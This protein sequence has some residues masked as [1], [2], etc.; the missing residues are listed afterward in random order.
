MKH[1]NYKPDT[2]ACKLCILIDDS[3]VWTV[4]ESFTNSEG[5]VH[6]TIPC[7]AHTGLTLAEL[8]D[9]IFAPTGENPKK[10]RLR[11]RL[12]ALKETADIVSWSW[13]GTGRTR[14]LTVVTSGLTA[15]EKTIAQTWCD[16]NFGSGKIIVT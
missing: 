3:S 1:Q 10:N 2:C 7:A 12:I 9:T 15:G 13:T 11:K 4:E 14:V 8:A 6:T 5:V 16:N